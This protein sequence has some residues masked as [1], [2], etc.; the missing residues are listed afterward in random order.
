MVLKITEELSDRVNRIVVIRA[1]TALTTTACY[2]TT[3]K[4]TAACS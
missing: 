1:A 4:N 2:S 3:A